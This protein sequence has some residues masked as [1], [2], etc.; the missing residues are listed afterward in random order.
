M[1]VLSI[2]ILFILLALISSLNYYT[3]PSRLENDS[4]NYQIEPN[5]LQTDENYIDN[6]SV[7]YHAHAILDEQDKKIKVSTTIEIDSDELAS[8]DTIFLF[9]GLNDILTNSVLSESIK[10]KLITFRNFVIDKININGVNKKLNFYRTGFQLMPDSAIYYANLNRIEKEINQI[11]VSLD[12]EI[13]ISPKS[14][15]HGYAS[16][17]EFYYV[18]NWLPRIILS[19]NSGG[20]RQTILKRIVEADNSSDYEIDLSIPEGY[21]LISSGE[22]AGSSM[23]NQRI[24]YKLASYNS[25]GLTWLAADDIDYAGF[26]IY[27]SPEKSVKLNLFLQP[28]NERY[29]D[30]YRDAAVNTIKYLHDNFNCM[31][32]SSFSLVDIPHT[33]VSAFLAS[34]NLITIKSELL[35]TKGL[36]DIE[37]YTARLI[38]KQFF[39]KALKLEGSVNNWI[40]EGLSTLYATEMVNKYF[41]PP[42]LSFKF[43]YQYP[44]YGMNHLSFN[45]IPIVYSLIELEYDLGLKRLS[46][47]YNDV[48][49]GKIVDYFYNYP[50]LLSYRSNKH[51]KPYLLLRS[52]IDEKG[53]DR[54]NTSLKNNVLNSGLKNKSETEINFI[55]TLYELGNTQIGQFINNSVYVDYAIRSV[56][57][58]DE[59]KYSILA[60]RIGDAVCDAKVILYTDEGNIEYDWAGKERFKYFTAVTN[61]PAHAAE[62]KLTDT[63]YLDINF[64]NNS[65]T[66]DNQYWGSLSLAIRVFFWFQN[67]IM[68]FG[69]AS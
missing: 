57:M 65:Y 5:H 36:A 55:N 43:A 44:V 68:I 31:A 38:S 6:Y 30:R 64:A 8:S 22:V 42:K 66:V 25:S 46:T 24:N 61:L 23:V 11:V 69:S 21:K 63:K 18:S 28:E 40:V 52:I 20:S 51:I 27:L 14:P 26:D 10:N 48:T 15:V 60:E 41:E 37:F 67:A 58:I 54:F 9:L 16:G 29:I 34:G 17:R 35:S 56:E 3:S 12:Y 19:K 32:F 39:K 1:K 59:N 62:I 53:I 4:D 13:N 50:N 7:N 45:D 33:S 2:I 47:Y 49:M